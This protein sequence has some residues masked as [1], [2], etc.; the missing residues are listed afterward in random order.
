MN[1]F[2]LT[3]FL[4]VISTAAMS[5]LP[6]R[7]KNREDKEAQRQEKR[8][9]IN[10]ML[11]LEEEGEP[12]FQ[13]HSIFGFKVNHD[14]YGLIWE[15]GRMKTPYKASIL[16][17]EINEKRH[18]K[19][20]KRSKGVDYGF[21]QVLGSPFSFG[22]I[23]HFYQLKGAWG[24]QVMI[25]NKGNKNGVAVYGIYS[26]GV[27]LGLVRPYYLEV[28]S[29]SP[30]IRTRVIKYTPSDSAAFLNY[31]LILAGTGLSNGW[32]DMRPVPG[33]HGKAA[34]RF[35]WSRFNNT[36]N[37]LEFGFNFE[38]YTSKIQQMATIEGRNFFANG[39][40]SLLFG[41]RK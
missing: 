18:Q 36:V 38:Y 30:P 10:A 20:D 14:G 34:L 11:R 13:S 1:R 33:L 19:E 25:G 4:L 40:V 16:Q 12:A 24:Q 29:R 6:F 8:Q 21:F 26:G 37:A 39:Y 17:I 15:K 23:N 5:Q 7:T 22:K 3:I 31:D 28:E 41:K 35:D 27:S 2:P 32:K 9:R